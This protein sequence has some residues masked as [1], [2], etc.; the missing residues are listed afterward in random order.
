MRTISMRL[1]DHTDAMLTAYCVQ[2]AVSQT[3]A[4]KAAIVHLAQA[5]RPTPAALAQ[6]LG[7]IGGFDSGAGDLAENHSQHLKQRLRARL[8]RDAMAADG[9]TIA[10]SPSAA[11]ARG[12]SGGRPAR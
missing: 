4:V 6:Q 5:Q 9:A 10:P 3:E 2:H 7:L 12:S 8:D 11:A 1:D